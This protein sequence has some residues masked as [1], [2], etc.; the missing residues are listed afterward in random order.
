MTT[1]MSN[2]A[3][4]VG[5]IF[6]SLIFLL[7][8]I[9]KI[10]GFAGTQAYMESMGVPG[11]LL[12]PVIALEISAAAAVMLGWH[13]RWFALAL[14]AFSIAAALFFHLD[15]SDRAQNILFWKNI[16]IAGGLMVIFAHG[17]GDLSLDKRLG[18]I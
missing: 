18:R 11:I 2:Y 6:M 13:T 7:S 1:N 5:R 15:F 3:E 9:N 16:A 4:L 17:P 8:G 14:A 12:P 10:G